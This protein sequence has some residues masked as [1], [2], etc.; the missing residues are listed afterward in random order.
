MSVRELDLLSTCP[1]C[2]GH[3]SFS[4]FNENDYHIKKYAFLDKF[5]RKKDTSI[6]VVV[7]KGCNGSGKNHYEY[8]ALELVSE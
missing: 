6:P 8:E 1:V 2:D 5:Y 3:G 4:F 7:C